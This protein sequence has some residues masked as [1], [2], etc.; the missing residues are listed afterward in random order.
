M[1]TTQEYD[2]IQYLIRPGYLTKQGEFESAK[3]NMPNP[4]SKK[5][6]EV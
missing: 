4:P 5:I 3:S 2:F 1:Y 6:L